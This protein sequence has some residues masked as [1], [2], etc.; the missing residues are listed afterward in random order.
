M[1]VAV[2]GDILSL[3]SPRSTLAKSFIP[4]AKATPRIP[5]TVASE[6]FTELGRNPSKKVGRLPTGEDLG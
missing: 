4:V 5:Q 3:P 6:F 1:R 2:A